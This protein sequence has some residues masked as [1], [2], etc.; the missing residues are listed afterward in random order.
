MITV[1][2][3]AVVIYEIRYGISGN[4]HMNTSH[5]CIHR[6]ST[7]EASEDYKAIQRAVSSLLNREYDFAD[8]V[9]VYV[10]D[11][12]IQEGDHWRHLPA[13]HYTQC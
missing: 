4:T 3:T 13:P 2:Y 6:T 11:I 5:S 9:T 10:H 8:K 12:Q 1:R 7:I